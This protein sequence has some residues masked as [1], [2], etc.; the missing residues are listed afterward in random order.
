MGSNDKEDVI[1]ENDPEWDFE[2]RRCVAAF[3][4]KKE[5]G[6]IFAAERINEPGAW[7]IPQGGAEAG[8]SDLDAIYRELWEETGIRSIKHLRSTK[9]RYNYDFPEQVI[10]KRRDRGWPY[11]KGQSVRFFLMEFEGEES[12]INLQTL[13]ESVEFSRWDWIPTEQIIARTVEFKKEAIL[14]GA[15]ELGLVKVE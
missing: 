2:Y 12:E 14:A 6:L 4:M 11:I 7:Q 3:V 1:A 13:P 9:R 15:T 5:S 8:E 10:K